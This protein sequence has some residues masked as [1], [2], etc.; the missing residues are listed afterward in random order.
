MEAL[1]GAPEL[2]DLIL[3]A[4]QLRDLL[5]VRL[6]SRALHA[7][8]QW[9][10]LPVVGFEHQDFDTTDIESVDSVTVH[11]QIRNFA[12][13]LRWLRR[14][15]RIWDEAHVRQHGVIVKR[16]RSKLL[17]LRGMSDASDGYYSLAP[18]WRAY[19]EVVAVPWQPER[20]LQEALVDND[21]RP[22]GPRNAPRASRGAFR[23]FYQRRERDAEDGFRTFYTTPAEAWAFRTRTDAAPRTRRIVLAPL[24]I[25]STKKADAS[26]PL[27]NETMLAALQ[28]VHEL[29]TCLLPGCRVSIDSKREL[30]VSN[31]RLTRSDAQGARRA[32]GRLV[33]QLSSDAFRGARLPIDEAVDA[34]LRAAGRERKLEDEP[35]IVFVVAPHLYPA[36]RVE[37]KDLAWVYST[38]VGEDDDWEEEDPRIDA[39]VVSTHQVESFVPPRMQIKE[40][41][42]VLLYCVLLEALG[43]HI[44]EN[45]DCVM[46]NNDSVGEME[47]VPLRL[48]P[49]CMRKLHL[50]GVVED[51]P[52]THCRVASF[53]AEKG[54]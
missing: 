9:R 10:F 38:D 48:C 13:Y 19:G 3:S 47:K 8:I 2:L 54:L 35:Y 50:M 24:D 51:V 46:N 52:A 17:E 5:P 39:W 7:R 28:T 41:C 26:M 37:G 22:G 12:A 36:G 44:C 21:A 25:V 11:N 16:V 20:W 15:W 30:R 4:L 1:E 53:L 49:T 23:L 18:W 27:L 43:L 42:K 14:W 6:A 31:G 32:D 45:L 29:I 40:V 34:D 33:R